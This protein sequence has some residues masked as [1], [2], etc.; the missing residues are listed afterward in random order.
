MV[1]FCV[2]FVKT[3]QTS[4]DTEISKDHV[5]FVINCSQ[6]NIFLSCQYFSMCYVQGATIGDLLVG[7]L[8]KNACLLIRYNSFSETSSW[9]NICRRWTSFGHLLNSIQLFPKINRFSAN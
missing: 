2:V 3:P 9:I 7:H 6:K 5:D 1:T 4:C 8:R